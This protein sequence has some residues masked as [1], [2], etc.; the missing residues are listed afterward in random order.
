[1]GAPISWMAWTLAGRHQSITGPVLRQWM[2]AVVWVIDPAVFLL[3]R[4]PVV[5]AAVLAATLALAGLSVVAVVVAGTRTGAPT[6]PRRR[7]RPTRRG[8]APKDALP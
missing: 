2:H 6:R 7:Q 1:V 3:R 5:S 8:R 4:G